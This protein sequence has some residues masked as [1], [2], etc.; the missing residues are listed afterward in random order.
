MAGKMNIR[1][2]AVG[3]TLRGDDGVGPAVLERLRR[4]NLP[5]N[6]GLVDSG[7]DPL[8][9]TTHLMDADKVIIIDAANMNMAPG[10]VEL[11][12]PEQLKRMQ[13][14]KP[15]S[16]HAYG[17]AEGVELARAA[18][19][20]PIISIIGVQPASVEENAGL[21]PEVAACI[22]EVLKIVLEEVAS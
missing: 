2:V 16:T 9:V 12:L 15:F 4:M 6:V 3:N 21:S 11:L 7:A 13:I 5:G 17:V 19:F 8:D 14:A 10:T 22:P 18:G 1:I 20:N